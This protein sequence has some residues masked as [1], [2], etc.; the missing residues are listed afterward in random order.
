MR[1]SLEQLADEG[2]AV[3]PDAWRA[4]RDGVGDTLG[5]LLCQQRAA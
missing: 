1:N 4:P 3:W 2:V 5:A